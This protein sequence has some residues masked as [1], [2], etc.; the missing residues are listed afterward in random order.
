MLS[1]KI[2][3]TAYPERFTILSVVSAEVFKF[4]VFIQVYYTVP[5][6]FIV[7]NIRIRCVTRGGKEGEISPALF[8]KLGKSALI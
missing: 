7:F 3:L 5:L 2:K 6:S 4:S 8:R 1:R